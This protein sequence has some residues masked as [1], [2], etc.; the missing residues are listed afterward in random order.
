MGMSQ[1]WYI[2]LYRLMAL[3]GNTVHGLSVVWYRPLNNNTLYT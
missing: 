3:E 2:S 1:L